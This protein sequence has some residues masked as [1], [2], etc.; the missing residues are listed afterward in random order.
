MGAHFVRFFNDEGASAPHFLIVTT[1]PQELE[2]EPNDFYTKPQVVPRMPVS[3]NGRLEKSGDVDCYAVSLAAGQTF[4]ASL[5]AHTLM[6]PVD[7]AVRLVNQQ[8]VTVASN[9]DDG[10]TMDPRL[11]WTATAAGTYVLQVFGFDYPAGSDVRFAGN[12]KCVYRLHLDVGPQLQH[13]WPLGVQCGTN[14][15]LACQAWGADT[16]HR[17][18]HRYDGTQLGPT[19]T[20][21]VFR[22]PGFVNE[23]RLPVG[24]GPE[25]VEIEPNH[26]AHTAQW[27]TLPG[28]VSGVIDPPGDVDRYQFRAVA[29]ETW[30]IGVAAAA[31]GF[32]LDAWLRIEDA[33]GK[34][35]VKVDDTE[36]ADPH[37]D[38][39]VPTGTN[40]VAV[41]GGLGHQGGRD[42]RYRLSFSRPV[43]RIKATVAEDAFVVE[44]GRTNEI[45]VAVTRR[46]SGTNLVTL[47]AV[48]LPPGVQAEPVTVGEKGGDV[49]IK[50]VATTE[51][52][53]SSQGF[54]LQV[55]ATPDGPVVP[56]VH[57][58]ISA[59]ENN[60][61]PQGF[62]HLVKES[63]DRLWLTVRPAPA[64]AP[65]DG[66]K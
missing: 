35:L 33:A 22:A 12:A 58:L 39:T 8:G 48:D 31:L 40:F 4:G 29:G 1:D 9:H 51:A 19:T 21:V 53:P 42:S 60:G 24:E 18:E 41:V 50:L 10:M 47:R 52:A 62:R 13:T 6:S 61:V 17:P 57:E 30:V 2:A 55:S 43:S 34:E 16:T 11:I 32:P 3:I 15:V 45:K 20:E 28:S 38:W 26:D 5:Q 56:V 65:A 23:L 46:F 36:S 63:V 64:P 7:A 27:V 66:K 25:Q 59:G 54:Q 44:A 37:L 49:V 14:T